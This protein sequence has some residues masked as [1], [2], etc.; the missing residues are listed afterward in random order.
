VLVSI[1]F[2]HIWGVVVQLIVLA[3]FARTVRVRTV[4]MAIAAGFY[5]CAAGAVF[6]N[7]RGS[8]LPRG[9]VIRRSARWFGRRHT[10]WTRSSRN[11]SRSFRWSCCCCQYEPFGSS[12]L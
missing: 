4:L 5:E 11:W 3:S 12:G 6:L 9:S 10:R 2:A 1:V 8:T 7:S